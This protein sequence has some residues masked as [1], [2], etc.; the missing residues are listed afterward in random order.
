MSEIVEQSANQR[1]IVVDNAYIRGAA[2]EAC[3][4]NPHHT[5]PCVYHQGCPFDTCA[6]SSIICQTGAI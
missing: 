1:H 2:C 3:V 6:I 4:L 5:V